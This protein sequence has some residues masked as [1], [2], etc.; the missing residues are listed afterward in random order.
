M[1]G[2]SISLITDVALGTT[3]EEYGQPVGQEADSILWDEFEAK[4][5][6]KRKAE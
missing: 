2:Q 5:L 1:W 4:R 6:F 3:Q